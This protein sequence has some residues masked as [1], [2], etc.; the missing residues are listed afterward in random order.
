[1]SLK[2]SEGWLKQQ[3]C[4]KQQKG[5]LLFQRQQV[6]QQHAVEQVDCVEGAAESVEQAS[7]SCLPMPD[8][9]RRLL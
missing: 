9:G 5:A 2:D 3:D 8:S 6:Q 1:M 7:C 4:D